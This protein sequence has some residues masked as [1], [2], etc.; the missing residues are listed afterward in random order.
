[1][2]L[3]RELQTG[4]HELKAL[5]TLSKKRFTKKPILSRRLYTKRVKSHQ[6]P[7]LIERELILSEKNRKKISR[8]RKLLNFLFPVMM[9]GVGDQQALSLPKLAQKN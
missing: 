2:T 1:M 4:L 8:G 9:R 5:T 6:E 7:H 3:L